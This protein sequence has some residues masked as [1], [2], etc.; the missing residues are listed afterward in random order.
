[1]KVPLW[2]LPQKLSSLV[3]GDGWHRSELMNKAIENVDQWW[4]A[5]MALDRTAD[6]FF[7]KAKGAVD[8]TNTYLLFGLDA[9][10]LAIV[11]FILL[12]TPRFP[13][14]GR[15]ARRHSVRVCGETR[16]A[17]VLLWGLGAVLAGHIGN[18]FAITYWDQT[19]AIWFMQLAAMSSVS[20]ACAEETAGLVRGVNPVWWAW[21]GQSA[22]FDGGEPGRSA[23]EESRGLGRG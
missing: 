21:N 13:R 19:Y 14:S 6:W 16:E 22:W 2:Y 17:E 20:R 5:G 4:L 23:V 10:L 11:L 9:G 8:I 15:G 3:G 7:Y 18:F 1:M 12:L